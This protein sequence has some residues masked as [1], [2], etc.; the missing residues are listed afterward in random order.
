MYHCCE[1]EKTFEQNPA[2]N[3]KGLLNQTVCPPRQLF[4]ASQKSGIFDKYKYKYS[5]W[6]W[7]R[8]V[9][10]FVSRLQKSLRPNCQLDGN[11]HGIIS[12][13]DFTIC[14]LEAPREAENTT[15]IHFEPIMLKSIATSCLFTHNLSTH[16]EACIWPTSEW[17]SNI[18]CSPFTFQMLHAWKVAYNW[19]IRAFYLLKTAASSCW[20]QDWWEQLKWNCRPWNQNNGLKD[21]KTLQRAQGNCRVGW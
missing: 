17:E 15:Q 5:V 7:Y 20:E 19:L 3:L 2:S 14:D 9:Y 13:V 1:L 18:C 11:V 12:P 4:R 16:L 6:R 8:Y 10:A 21:A